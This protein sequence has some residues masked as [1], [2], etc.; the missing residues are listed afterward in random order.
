MGSVD[1]AAGSIVGHCSAYMRLH[2]YRKST[3]T[4][5]YVPGDPS[6]SFHASPTSPLVR[7]RDHSRLL[8][9]PHHVQ[10]SPTARPTATTRRRVALRSMRRPREPRPLRHQPHPYQRNARQPPATSPIA[11]EPPGSRAHARLGQTRQTDLPDS[12]RLAICVQR[13]G[14]EPAAARLSACVASSISDTQVVTEF[15]V[16]TNAVQRSRSDPIYVVRMI[17]FQLGSRHMDHPRRGERVQLDVRERSPFAAE[18]RHQCP[19]IRC[20]CSCLAVEFVRDWSETR[21]TNRDRRKPTSLNL[22]YLHHSFC[23][24]NSG[25]ADC[26]QT[27]R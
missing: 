1:R 5:R 13:L 25:H 7:Y 26:K 4:R 20:V 24:V 6:T 12:S 17:Q 10:I 27:D 9:P 21:V 16:F 15:P 18:Y 23:R 2:V 8:L 22:N 11:V 14:E 3:A 19:T